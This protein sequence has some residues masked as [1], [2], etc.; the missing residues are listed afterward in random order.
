MSIHA[1]PPGVRILLPADALFVIDVLRRFERFR[2]GYDQKHLDAAAASIRERLGDGAVDGLMSDAL[3]LD[4]EL[5]LRTSGAFE[6]MP[7]GAPSATEHELL[8]IRMIA[9]MQAGEFKAAAGHATQLEIVQSRAL[10]MLV[11]KIAARLADHGLR[12]D[13]GVLEPSWSL[14][15]AP[16]PRGSAGRAPGL[17]IVASAS[18]LG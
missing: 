15:H 7:E 9:C 13:R 18:T 1:F 16:P 14:P 10:L 11:N 5:R 2:H 3:L 17:R 6:C 4:N 12:L 8:L